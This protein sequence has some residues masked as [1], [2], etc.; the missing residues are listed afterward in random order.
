MKALTVLL[1]AGL[2]APL[3]AQAP[4]APQSASVP[5]STASAAIPLGT[6][7]GA[8]PTGYDDGGRRDPFSSLIVSK[9][10]PAGAAADGTRPRSGLGSLALADV[11]V[12]GIIRGG[13]VTMAILEG[14]SKQSFTVRA[15]DRL[16]D[17][18]VVSIDADSVVFA[19]QTP[20]AA[21]GQ[22]KKAL[23]PADEGIR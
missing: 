17:A 14:P 15:K 18:V 16:F 4:A 8:L 12:R 9:H 2:T 1:A 7:V 23:R 13:N 22:V 5:I 20:G 21:G 6:R 3:A 11:T 10:G 19:D